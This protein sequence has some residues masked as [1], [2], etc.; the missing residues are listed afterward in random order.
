M[1]PFSLID[2]AVPLPLKIFNWDKRLDYGVSDRSAK[3]L[4]DLSEACRSAKL[5]ADLSEIRRS[6]KL[7][8]DLSVLVLFFTRSTMDIKAL[9]LS[10]LSYAIMA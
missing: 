8:A 1:S 10:V 9:V 5:L 6:A 4:A 2:G 3:I 7:L